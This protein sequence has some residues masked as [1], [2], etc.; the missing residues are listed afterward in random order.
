LKNVKFKAGMVL[1]F[2]PITAEVSTDYKMHPNSWNLI[3]QHGDL[4]C[5]WE[6]T[7]AITNT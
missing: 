2:E 3:T 4:G 5:Q 7:I 1:A 6:Y